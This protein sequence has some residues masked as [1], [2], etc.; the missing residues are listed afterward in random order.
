MRLRSHVFATVPGSAVACCLA[1]WN[2]QV[3]FAINR[4]HPRER[5]RSALSCGRNLQ[6]TGPMHSATI[7]MSSHVDCH[8]PS[9]LTVAMRIAANIQSIFDAPLGHSTNTAH[10]L[11]RKHHH[12]ATALA[13]RQWR[14]QAATLRVA[15]RA[16]V[17]GKSSWRPLIGAAD[18]GQKVP[19][20]SRVC[21]K[22]ASPSANA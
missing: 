5:A 9:M 11:F 15:G 6:C 8:R 20:I 17:Q 2:S 10:A 21:Q 7:S 14:R 19:Q 12:R 16:M 4:V 3:V 22:L 18:A 13:T 1:G